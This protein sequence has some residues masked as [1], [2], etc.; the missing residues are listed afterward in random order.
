MAKVTNLSVNTQSG[1]DSTIYAKWSFKGKNLDHYSVSFK[2]GTGQGVWFEGSKSDVKSKNATYNPPSNAI[3]VKVYVKPV[4]K[5][6][7]VNGKQKS[8]WSGTWVSKIYELKQNLKPAQPSAPTVSID[9]YKLTA[10]VNVAKEQTTTDQIEFYVL[11]DGKKFT[12]GVANVSH[13][14]ATYSCNV[15]AGGIYRV[16]CRAI[17]LIGKSKEYSGW[18]TYSSDVTTIP[19]SIS[20]LKCAVE[21]ETSVR[22]TW[23]GNSSATNYEVQ[24]TT[25]R[26]YFDTSSEV[27]SQNVTNPS[28]YIT[29]LESG[30]QWYFRVRATNNQGE[31][32]WSGIVSAIIGSKPEPPT[33]WS[34]TTTA[35]IGESL[36]L[37]WVHNSEDESK[38]VAAQIEL[39]INGS[40]Q[41]INFDSSDNE[42]DEL[43]KIYSYALDTTDYNDG[44]E[45]LWRIRTRGILPTYSDW[46]IQRKID[47]YAP[48]TL[49]M[50][51]G[52]DSGILQTLPY[53]IECIA[54]PTT[55]TP[56]GYNIAITNEES[57]ET[58]DEIGNTTLVPAG[59][60]VYSKNFNVTDNPFELNLEAG[61]LSLEN[62]QTYIVKATVSMNSGLI[63]E[64]TDSFT[65]EWIDEIYEP[66]AA[67]AIDS[68]LLCAYI[69]PFC[70]NEDGSL[71]EDVTLSVF[72]REYDGE[73]TEI[74]SDLENDGVITVT[75][76]HPSLDYA[77]YR[78]AARSKT[79]GMIG[80]EDLPGEPIGEPSIVIQW[81]EE[82]TQFDY[83]EEAEPE[84]PPWTGSMV[85]LPYNVDI[86]EKHDKDVSLINYIGRKHPV[87][88]YGT[89]RGEGGTWSTVID[90]EDNETL[91]ALRRLAA[92]E[93]DV[94]IREPSGIGY[95]AQITV[96]IST[97]HRELTIP[98]SFDIK[99]VEGSA[100]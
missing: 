78:I 43:T 1:S 7:K 38:Q 66:D 12:S 64:A 35:I 25:K 75:D 97:K 8:Y 23:T 58:E 96:S 21:S 14:R 13:Q 3:K 67:I 20:N 70:E 86:S 49:E 76:P 80:Y 16:C 62:N 85:R 17:N 81:D 59:T 51:L 45:I 82:W 31:S 53:V 79:T 18:S 30:R 87:S 55:Q 6:H 54:A 71:N 29:G 90:K 65:V 93:G 99:R 92:W 28:A 15:T 69:S 100:I 46:S 32:G 34:S 74:A 84:I 44:A 91:Y 50:H 95:W 61:D 89:Q 88:Y 37:Y 77:R 52:D 19:P 27:S 42:D 9:K 36:Y 83:A 22:L 57:Y 24:Y 40:S 68:D 39:T 2:Y 33:T 47:I 63:A 26:E 60:E 94:Y 10:Y 98:I 73:F 5:K 11:K 56:T 41:T 4:S 48:P 72:R